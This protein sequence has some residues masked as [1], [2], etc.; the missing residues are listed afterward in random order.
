MFW[1]ELIHELEIIPVWE[2]FLTG[3][4]GGIVLTLAVIAGSGG[5]K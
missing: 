3:V 2:C 1:Q 4:I 5:R